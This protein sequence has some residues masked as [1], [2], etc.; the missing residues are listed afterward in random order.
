MVD[1]HAGDRM[2]AQYHADSEAQVQQTSPLK[3]DMPD[4][5]V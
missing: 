4:L 3:G 2:E 1:S 5:I